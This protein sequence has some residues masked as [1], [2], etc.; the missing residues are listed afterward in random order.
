MEIFLK[1]YRFPLM[2]MALALTL[3]LLGH[4]LVGLVGVV[5]GIIDAQT[6]L[7]DAQAL[8]SGTTASSNTYDSLLAGNNIPAGE[9]LAVNLTV[10]VAAST[11]N[12]NE[13]YQ[14]QVIQSANSDLSSPD[15][16]VETTTAFI[17]RAVLVQGK[18]LTIP[19]PPN[20]KTKRYLGVQYV[21]GG[22]SPTITVT[23]EII[24]LKFAQNEQVY[25][26]NYKITS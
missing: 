8:T 22:T 20:M 10:D 17:T 7:S 21:L 2:V 24:P 19:I 18:R 15:V 14:I 9:P 26:A 6:L 16:I 1:K 25:P 12:G 23:T 11:A 13:T 4:P 5:G 3:A